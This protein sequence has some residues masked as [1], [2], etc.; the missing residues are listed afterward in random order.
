[1]QE[2]NKIKE[3]KRPPGGDEEEYS[4]RCQFRK[5][6]DGIALHLADNKKLNPLN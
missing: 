2:N 3:K 6:G 4:S 5:S 1:L